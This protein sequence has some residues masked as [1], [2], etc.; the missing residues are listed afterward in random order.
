MSSSTLTP[1]VP[2]YDHKARKVVIF[3]KDNFPDWERTCEAV[4]IM[5][6]GWDFVTGDKDLIRVNIADKR[7]RRGEA[8]K[9]IF[10]SVRSTRQEEMRVL[11]KQ[12]D[13]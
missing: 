3:N 4:L 11:I 10:N 5:A 7:K 8:L 13:I 2:T 12:H 6:K 9:I 1:A